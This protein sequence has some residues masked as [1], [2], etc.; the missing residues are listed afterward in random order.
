MNIIEFLNNL[1]HLSEKQKN[2]WIDILCN[3]MGGN[4]TIYDLMSRNKISRSTLFRLISMQGHGFLVDGKLS[5]ISIKKN[6]ITIDNC[7][8]KKDTK[9]KREPKPKSAKVIDDVEQ[10]IS[11]LNYKTGKSFSHKSKSSVSFINARIKEGYKI[12]D[13]KRVV[14]VKCIK[15]K[16]SEF[17]DYLR[18]QTLFSNKMD[19]YLNETVIVKKDKVDK[20]NDTISKAK[21]FDWESSN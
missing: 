8:I 21:Q 6:I 20:A 5:K 15:W 19:G 3:C 7:T 10:I 18:P 14:D 12:E 11:Y 2:A 16:N 13:F 9:T 4:T 17:E 1:K